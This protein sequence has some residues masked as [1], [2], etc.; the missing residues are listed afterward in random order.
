GALEVWLRGIEGRLETNK[1]HFE[2]D[3][4]K[5]VYI[6]SRL[7]PS[8][9]ADILPY[10][11]P[12][13]PEQIKNS[14][15]LLEHLKETYIDKNKRS[16]ASTELYTL[17][18]NIN[19][20]FDAF[21]IK[22]IRAA[23]AAHLPK[24]AWKSDFENRL[25][26]ELTGPSAASFLDDSVTFNHYC[27]IISKIAN[28]EKRAFK[29]KVQKAKDASPRAA[30]SGGG[31]A[32]GTSTLRPSGGQPRRAPLPT[33]TKEEAERLFN[34][35]RCFVCEQKGHLRKECPKRGK[36][37]VDADRKARL[38]MIY[39]MHNIDDHKDY[40]D[41]ASSGEEESTN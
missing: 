40:D 17:E 31:R 35:G 23:G 24:V 22:Y 34:E 41:S 1:D 21:K 37:N 29:G 10:Y 32:S 5:M 11:D 6:E 27:Q 33:R 36:Q 9:V 2:T 30:G 26:P 25:P 38:A 39:R 15:Q 8:V 12:H 4:A 19:Q 7:D 28:S 3:R 16:N 13:H 14:E 18:M 20:D